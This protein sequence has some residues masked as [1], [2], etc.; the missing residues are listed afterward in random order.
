MRR[1]PQRVARVPLSELLLPE[2]IAP[3]IDVFVG[4]TRL[5]LRGR[6]DAV[7]ERAR[8]LGVFLEPAAFDHHVDVELEVLETGEAPQGSDV[9]A[10]GFGFVRA[11]LAFEIDATRSS[12]R[13][14]LDDSVGAFE[15]TLELALQTALLRLGGLVVHASCGV[16]QGHAW[17]MPGPSGAGKSTAARAGGFDRVLSD[18]MVVVRRRAEGFEAFGTPFWSEGRV[19]PYDARPA[20]LGVLARLNKAP[21]IAVDGLRADDAVAHLIRCVAFYE[22]SPQARTRA[23][24]LAIEL[25]GATTNVELTFPKEGIWVAAAAHLMRARSSSTH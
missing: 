22:D 21:R 3:H 11:D 5:R 9:Q 10:G 17:L 4:G 12:A 6:V 15:A 25:V 7:R 2:L 8:A 24:E 1:L 13:A 19:L 14:T 16:H 18:E 23:F 20:P